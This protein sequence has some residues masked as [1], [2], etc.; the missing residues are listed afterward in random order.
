MV[1]PE[2]RGQNTFFTGERGH[3]LFYL[4]IF[5]FASFSRLLMLPFDDR[6]LEK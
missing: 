6:A 5:L 3:F 2:K 1:M 4:N